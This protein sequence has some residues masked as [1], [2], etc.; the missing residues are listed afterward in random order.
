M[1]NILKTIK[2]IHQILLNEAFYPLAFATLV[3]VGVFGVRVYFSGNSTYSSLVR[4]LA[5]AWI[6][7]VLS[8]FAVLLQ[9]ALGH[10]WKTLGLLLPLA[11]AWL[12]FFP[13]AP[14]IVTDFYDLSSRPPLPLWF[15]IGMI[16]LY[17]L[18][19]CLLAVASLRS[20][21]AIF[22]LY[23]G[24]FL[25]WVAA[26]GVIAISAAGVYLGRFGRWNSWDFFISPRAIVKQAI[27]PAISPGE[28]LGFI[29]FSMLFGAIL[30]VLYVMYVSL[31]QRKEEEIEK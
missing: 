25:S 19:G 17:A 7:Y 27:L 20:M 15:D 4:N 11:L 30:L 6:P 21:Q 12:L 10:G 28:N 8:I 9:R 5:L 14:Y 26:V 3:A 22:R 29:G 2:Q 24:N 16:S 23:A 1:K 18:S 13:N 31:N